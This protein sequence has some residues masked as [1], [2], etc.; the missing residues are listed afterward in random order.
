MLKDP[1]KVW[2]ISFD[3]ISKGDNTLYCKEWSYVYVYEM[4][5]K[6]GAPMIIIGINIIVPIVFHLLAEFEHT[7]TKTE[8][9]ERTFEKVAVL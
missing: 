3:N 1:K 4:A 6:F 2:A 7:T 9:T 5:L 8:E